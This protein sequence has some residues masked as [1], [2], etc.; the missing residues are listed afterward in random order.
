MN[1]DR[2]AY[3][4]GLIK[5]VSKSQEAKAK[6]DGALGAKANNSAT[7]KSASIEGN[8]SAKYEKLEKRSLRSLKGGG[9]DKELRDGHNMSTR[10][11][12]AP[13][14]RPAAPKPPV[15]NP[16]AKKPASKPKR[17]ARSG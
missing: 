8:E 10:Q 13:G 11:P 2:H 6:G 17:A 15:V 5:N 7:A 14:R 9:T 3:L 16:G 1:N 12:V 4:G